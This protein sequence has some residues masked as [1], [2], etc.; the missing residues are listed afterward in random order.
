MQN[1]NVASRTRL[2]LF[3]TLL[4]TAILSGYL[5]FHYFELRD[6][7]QRD[8]TAVAESTANRLARQLAA[9]LWSINEQQVNATLE[10]EMSQ[11]ELDGVE[12]VDPVDGRVLFERARDG[13]K[14]GVTLTEQAAITA[15]QTV[16]TEAGEPIGIA[17][18]HIS[19]AFM[20]TTLLAAIGQRAVELFVLGILLVLSHFLLLRRWSRV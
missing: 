5:L 15:K 9:P 17:R 10:S 13:V 3:V 20:H 16:S 1:Q 12:I 18:V 19:R 2:M 14:T 7:L 8:M 11:S 4:V 6:N